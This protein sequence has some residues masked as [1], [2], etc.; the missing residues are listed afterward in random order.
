VIPTSPPA[1][2]HQE[3]RSA[4]NARQ[5]W[6]QSGDEQLPLER[7][8]SGPVMAGAVGGPISRF[9]SISFPN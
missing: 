7:A 5:A 6:L 2:H 4:D 3:I 9:V 8:I 1:P